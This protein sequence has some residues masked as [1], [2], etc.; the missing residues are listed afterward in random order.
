MAEKFALVIGC[1]EY[2]DPK[3]PRLQ[4]PSGDIQDLAALIKNPEIGNFNNV[5]TLLNKPFSTVSLEIAKL[6]TNKNKDDLLLLYFSGHGVL[7]EQGRLYFAMQDTVR[8]LLSGSAIS[9]NF[10]HDEMDNSRSKRQL[11]ILDCCH[12]G[13]FSRGTKS[14]IGQKVITNSTFKSDSYGRAVLTATDSTQYAWEGNKFVGTTENSLFTHYLL[15]GLR[16]GN[17]DR[18]RDGKITPDELY[19]YTYEKVRNDT[20]KQKPQFWVYGQ[21]GKQITVAFAPT[22]RAETPIGIKEKRENLDI[23]E[24]AELL[25][26]Q[27]RDSTIIIDLITKPFRKEFIDRINSPSDETIIRPIVAIAEYHTNIVLELWRNLT[28]GGSPVKPIRHF[29]YLIFYFAMLAA[30]I[31][32]YSKVFSM[33][34]L[35]YEFPEWMKYNGFTVLTGSLLSLAIGSLIAS[36]I[37][38]KTENSDFS[39]VRS[40]QLNTFIKV[41]AI[42]LIISGLISSISLGFIQSNN[43]GGFSSFSSIIINVAIPINLLI[44][45]PLMNPS[46]TKGFL[47]LF[48]FLNIPMIVFEYLLVYLF[49]L[50][51]ALGMFIL[52]VIVRIIFILWFG[53]TFPFKKQ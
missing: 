45:T 31:A 24:V 18:D 2:Q 9:A 12:S 51:R 7:D 36:D 46:A 40:S 20:K 37:F 21:E 25:T 19:N 3:L 11:L 23:D 28:L 33:L 38:G 5:V 30:D 17:A 34:G 22:S 13:A 44:A 52:T 1:N 53:V 15:D 49:R 39:E 47:V 8:N 16:T 26:K 32:I 43:L 27:N 4:A 6:F 41:G 50:I 42:L 48:I 35:N 29:L 10:V 14:A